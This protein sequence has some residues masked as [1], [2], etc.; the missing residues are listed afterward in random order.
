MYFGPNF[1]VSTGERG[2]PRAV[3]ALAVR[4]RLARRRAVRQ[5][6][7]ALQPAPR[8]R[9]PS[10]VLLPRRRQSSS[11]AHRT[12]FGAGRRVT[13]AASEIPELAGQDFS[14]IVWSRWTAIVVERSMFWRPVGTPPGTPWVGGHT[15]LGVDGTEH[16]VVLRRGRGGA[17][18]R[19]LL[20]DVQPDRD[21]RSRASKRTS[22]PKRTASCSAST[23]CRPADAQTIYC[24]ARARQHR[25]DRPRSC[26]RTSRSSP[27]AR[28]TGAPDASKAPAR[29]ASSNPAPTLGPAGRRR[30][31]Q[32]RDLPAARQSVRVGVARRPQRA[33][34]GLRPDHAAAVD[35]QDRAGATAV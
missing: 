33:D 31:R 25:R 11:P 12:P 34:R 1:E 20:P 16:E 19:D 9:R 5:L 24:N 18:L 22:S 3:H 29:S 4:G 32:L 8:G 2:Q 13:L 26:R 15:R 14:T 27:S 30:R 6:L 28:S 23:T 21:A 10:R 7:P 35:A 17:R